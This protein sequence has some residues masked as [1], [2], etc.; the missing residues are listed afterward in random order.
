MLSRLLAALVATTLA[1]ACDTVDDE[2]SAPIGEAPAVGKADG[3]DAAERGCKIVLRKFARIPRGASFETTNGYWVWRA[4]VDV[5]A[6][7]ANSGA[8]IEALYSANGG[9]WHVFVGTRVV[10]APDAAG[11]VRYQIRVDDQTVPTP[12]MELRSWEFQRA[13]LAV[14][15][16]VPGQGRLFDHNRE[17]SD[18]ANYVL[19]PTT[20]FEVGEAPAICP[21]TVP[22]ATLT[23]DGAFTQRQRGTIVPGGVV[24]VKYD[25]GRLPRCRYSSGGAQLWDIEA[26]IKFQPMGTVVTRSVTQVVP[27]GRVSV[28]TD[29][30]VP[31]GTQYVDLWFHNLEAQQHCD[32]Y[33]SNFG[34]NYRFGAGPLPAAPSWAGNWGSSLARDCIARPGVP[35]PMVIDSYVRERACSFVEAEVYAPGFTDGGDQRLERMW[36]QAIPTIGGVAQAPIDLEAIGRSG[37]NWRYRFTL[38]YEYRQVGF[39][40]ASYFLRFSAD[41]NTWFKIGQGAGPT[42]GAARTIVSR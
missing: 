12:L 34:N 3:T 15:A 26:T 8:R 19:S 16:A 38:P 23:F 5:D 21:A 4:E 29:F 33:D 35:E 31:L 25:L 2:G 39:A 30:A 11:R 13:E 6:A 37:N 36:A 10:G 14:Y 18:L 28:P 32:E 22:R 42:G 27:G 24:T 17:T 7:L 20:N 1:M 41:G 9:A 40:G